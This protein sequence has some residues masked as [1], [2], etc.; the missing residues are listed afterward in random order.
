MT[1]CVPTPNYLRPAAFKQVGTG[2]VIGYTNGGVSCG[3]TTD[4]TVYC[5]GANRGGEVGNGDSTETNVPTAVQLPAG[6]TFTAISVGDFH[7]CGL[8]PDG[9]AWCW[10]QWFGPLPRRLPLQ[11]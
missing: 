3:L 8:T 10:G 1:E 9:V 5:W 6:T 11:G 7:A 4:G 2:G